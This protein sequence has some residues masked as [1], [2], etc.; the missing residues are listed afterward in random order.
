MIRDRLDLDYLAPYWQRTRGWWSERSVREQ[1]L[2]GSLA[3][4][5]ILGLLLIVLA[6]IREARQDSLADIRNAAMLDA[7]LRSGGESMARLGTFRRGTPSA[8]VTNSL[9]AAQLEVGQID[10]QG[11]AVRVVLQDAPFDTVITW[12]ADVEG[13]SNLRVRSADIDR[14]GAPGFVSATFVLGE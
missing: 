6:P 1:I 4:I 10:D 5:G 13:T 12:I 11:D 2:L 3:A 8:I 9:A 14:Q 7:R